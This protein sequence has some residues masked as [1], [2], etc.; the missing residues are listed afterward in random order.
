VDVSCD[1]CSR[2]AAALRTRLTAAERE[3]IEAQPTENLEA[4]DNYLR[5]RHFWTQRSVG[6]FAALSGAVSSR[7]RAEGLSYSAGA[8]VLDQAA[9]GGGPGT[10]LQESFL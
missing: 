8:W 4:Y 10:G 7:I 6:Y 9:A 1:C 2:P 3:R 5:G